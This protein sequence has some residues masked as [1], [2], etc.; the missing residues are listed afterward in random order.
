MTYWTL[1]YLLAP[2]G[3]GIGNF[4]LVSWLLERII[5]CGY[6]PKY[7]GP[8]PAVEESILFLLA[9]P[10]IHFESAVPASISPELVN[11][12]LWAIA[13]IALIFLWAKFKEGR[14]H[15]KK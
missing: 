4:L 3:L 13:S 2:L 7:C 1:K 5:R 14:E 11:A 8:Y 15:D 10:T 6:F 12:V 9:F